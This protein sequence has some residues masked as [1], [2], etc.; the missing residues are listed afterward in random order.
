MTT[1][2]KNLNFKPLSKKNHKIIDISGVF[3]PDNVIDAT[4]LTV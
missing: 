2:D 1:S 3:L 4:I